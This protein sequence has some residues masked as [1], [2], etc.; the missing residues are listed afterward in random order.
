MHN[1]LSCPVCDEVPRPKNIT[2]YGLCLENGHLT[3]HRCSVCWIEESGTKC[4][5]CRAEPFKTKSKN[6]LADKVLTD[7]SN[8]YIYKCDYCPL[9]FQGKAVEDHELICKAGRYPCPVCNALV[10]FKELFRLRHACIVR[11]NVYSSEQQ[12]WHMK[13][14]FE[15]LFKHDR[16]ILLIHAR[17]PIRACLWYEV[18]GVGL[19]IRVFWVDPKGVNSPQSSKVKICMGIHTLAGTLYRS[20][21]A[22]INYTPDGEERGILRNH[23]E[24][25]MPTLSKWDTYATNNVCTRCNMYKPH[26]HVDLQIIE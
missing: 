4:P 15:S 9:T 13:F 14:D 20:K 22:T 5:I 7:L 1:D 10:T 3:C 25:L 23:L 8:L 18:T 16:G 17:R 19:C 6:V 21:E 26:A 2:N 12:G 24:I 11:R